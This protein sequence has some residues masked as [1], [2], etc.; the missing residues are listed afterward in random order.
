MEGDLLDDQ[1]EELL[2]RATA[3]LQQ[4]ATTQELATSRPKQH[5]NFPKLDTGKVEKPYISS[6]GDVATVD[7]KRLLEEK[8]RKQANTVRNVEDPVTAKK[9]ALEAKKATAG[10]RWFNLPRTDLTP[11][12]KRDLQLLKMRNVLDPHRHYKKDGGKMQ[13]PEYS[14][15]GTIIEG[16]TE[17]FSGRIENKQRKKTFVEEV[18]AGE[19]ETGRFKRKYGELQGRKTSGKKAFYKAMKANRKI[20]EVKK[21]SG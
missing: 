10:T 4:K 18:L 7:A 14:Q 1:I 2:A 9:T 12:L 20:G 6:K 19:Q 16:P 5:F 21:G 8:Q 11:Q 13:A 15:V 17:F 3:R